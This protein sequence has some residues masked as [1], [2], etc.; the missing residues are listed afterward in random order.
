MPGLCLAAPIEWG[1]RAA[2][3]AVVLGAGVRRAWDEAC[4][5]FG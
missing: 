4:E 3:F 1:S 5:V 2:M